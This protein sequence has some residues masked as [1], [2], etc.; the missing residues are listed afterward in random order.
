MPMQSH[1]YAFEA[2]NDL[3][4]SFFAIF[5]HPFLD[6]AA[7]VFIDEGISITAC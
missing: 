2:N 6:N 5:F 1:E 7:N 4:D 3:R